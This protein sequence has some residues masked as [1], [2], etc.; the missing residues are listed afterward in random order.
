MSQSE[1]PPLR[2]PEADGR[3]FWEAA[4]KGRL[5][6]QRCRACGTVRFP[7]RHQCN[8]CWSPDTEWFDASGHGEI[9]SI[10]IVRRAPTA[11][12]RDRVPFVLVAVTLTEGVRMITNLIG[13]RAMEG[14][15]GNQV[16]VC[17]ESRPN[18]ALPQ[19]RLSEKLS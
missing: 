15:I 12:Y 5:V 18:G 8:K 2:E 14:R 7:P 19:F 4:A 17:F 13:D 9:E 6:L 16:E 1:L 11:A 3:P 10:T